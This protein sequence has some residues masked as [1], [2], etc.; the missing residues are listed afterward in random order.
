MKNEQARKNPSNMC[1]CVS[2]KPH[3]PSAASWPFQV[4]LLTFSSTLLF[5]KSIF[6]QR[7]SVA[8]EAKRPRCDNTADEAESC[9]NSKK[10]SN[11]VDSTGLARRSPWQSQCHKRFLIIW[12]ILAT[13]S[14]LYTTPNRLRRGGETR[15]RRQKGK[16]RRIHEEER[17]KEG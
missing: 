8:L 11:H 5:I 14:F 9:V 16:R 10:I 3:L 7:F 13:Q 6:L 12:G 2:V 4:P 17:E 1:V 15:A